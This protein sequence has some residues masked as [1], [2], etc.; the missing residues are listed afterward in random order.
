MDQYLF[1]RGYFPPQFVQRLLGVDRRELR[2]MVDEL[3]PTDSMPGSS[4]GSSEGTFNRLEISRYLHDQLLRDSDV[5]SMAHSIELR[6]PLLASRIVEYV[7]PL[8]RSLKVRPGMNKPLLVGAAASEPVAHAGRQA[9]RGFTLPMQHW[10][11]DSSD[12]L[13]RR[14]LC[15]PFFDAS[16]V[17]AVWSDFREGRLHWSRAWGLTVL[18]S[19]AAEHVPANLTPEWGRRP[20]EVRSLAATA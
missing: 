19:I 5:F 17:H 10:L 6:V 11:R 9:K 12:E 13:E 15:S 2:R 14:A 7:L 20:V 4:C 3:F 16:S 8:R 1:L 18:G